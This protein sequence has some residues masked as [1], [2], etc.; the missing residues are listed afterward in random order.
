MDGRCRQQATTTRPA[1]LLQ[2]RRV[3]A[4]T[5][6]CFPKFVVRLRVLAN[7]LRKARGTSKPMILVPLCDLKFLIKFAARDTGTSNRRH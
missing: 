7:E 6:T 1:R 3:S 4:K 5:S 2:A